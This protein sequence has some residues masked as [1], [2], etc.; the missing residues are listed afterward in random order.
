MDEVVKGM[1]RLEEM[2]SVVPGDQAFNHLALDLRIKLLGSI[3]TWLD[4]SRLKLASN[5]I[6]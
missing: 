4:E 3:I 1:Q 5:L 2:Q 6:R